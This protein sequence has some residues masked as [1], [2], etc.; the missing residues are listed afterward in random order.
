MNIKDIG[1]IVRT[2]RLSLG[3]RMD[4]V[5]RKANIS[6]V[7]LSMIENGCCNYSFV[8]LLRVFDCLGLSLSISNLEEKTSPRER[9]PKILTKQEKQINRFIVMCI[10]DY[11]KEKSISGQQVYEMMEENDLFQEMTDDYEDLH[12][13]SSSYLNYY[14]EKMITEEQR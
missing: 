5:A 6:R 13:M 4:D 10:E 1:L 12:G 8:N 14:I 7:T 11:A 2:K 9:A 3:L